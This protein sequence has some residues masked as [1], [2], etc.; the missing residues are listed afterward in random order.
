MK[1]NKLYKCPICSQPLD[2]S[3]NSYICKSNHTFDIAKEGYVNLYFCSKGAKVDAGDSK[4]MCLDRRKFLE[5]GF[6]KAAA[7]KI[8]NYIHE[9][10]KDVTS[11]KVIIDA[12]CGEGYYLR[13]FHENLGN[14]YC[15]LGIDLAKEGIKLASKSAKNT[16]ANLSFAVAGIFDLPF[17]DDCAH[18]VTSIFAPICETEFSRVL[19]K[20]GI[21]IVLCPA[22]KHLYG[23]KEKIYE[24]ARENTEKIPEYEGFQLISTERITY[25]INVQKE[26][27]P[28]LFGMT[29]YYWKSSKQTQNAVLEL[30]NLDTPCDF[31]MKVYKKI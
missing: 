28:A 12:G 13:T 30:E 7:D 5:Q 27:I 15:Y 20:G 2:I 21:F 11:P 24:T 8:S 31:L 4:Q 25:D 16:S 3:G 29:P 6:Y 26:F 17:I 14:N 1:T 23:L 18:V 22:E 19:K 9:T 10:F